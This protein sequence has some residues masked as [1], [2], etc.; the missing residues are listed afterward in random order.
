MQVDKQ[1]L[2][3]LKMQKL[4]VIIAT[5]L[6]FSCNN[7]KTPVFQQAVCS[8][9][10]KGFLYKSE[11]HTDQSHYININDNT[12][13]FKS[14]ELKQFTLPLT[15]SNIFSYN[16]TKE[17]GVFSYKNDTL[18]NSLELGL[19]HYYCWKALKLK[20]RNRLSFSESIN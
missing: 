8:V 5:L 19:I 10:K 3:A 11:N 15:T 1:H 7:S 14:T 6:L 16:G 17:N 2:Q 4:T 13:N 20:Y 18:N 12:I 9:D